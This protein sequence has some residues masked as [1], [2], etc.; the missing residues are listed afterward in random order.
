MKIDSSNFG[1]S[2]RIRLITN[3]A[4][5]KENGENVELHEC[6]EKVKGYEVT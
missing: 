5:C 1:E 6:K 4:K 3:V 2:K